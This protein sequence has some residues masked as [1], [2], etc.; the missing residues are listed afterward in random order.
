MCL[1]PSSF[2]NTYTSASNFVCGWIV[3]G[4]ANTCPLSMS[5]LCTPLSNAPM[6]SPASA[7][8]SC[9]LNIST[10]VT[11]T[12]LFSVVSPTISTLSPTFTFPLSTLPVA[13]V[14]RPVIVKM[15]STGIR[16][17]W[18]TSLTGAGIHS[19][20]SSINFMILSPHSPSGSSN[21]FNADPTTIGV[22][23]P[24]YSYSFNNSRTSI[25][26]NS[27][28]SGSSTWSSLFKNT[29]IFGTP[30]CLANKMCSLVCGIGPSAALTTR[31][32]PSI[33]AAPVIMFLT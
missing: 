19:S 32:A 9:F 1:P 14:P 28:S 22:L 17:G 8:S 13:T 20:T 6:L 2:V 24:S 25:S 16:N 5:S 18:S 11:T 21:A 31:I 26:T 23:S 10:P 33:C 30:T 15:S 7:S 3:P 4:A 27:I 12:V 29:A